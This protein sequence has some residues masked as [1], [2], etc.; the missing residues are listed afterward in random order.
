MT[1][2]GTLTS[3]RTD[4]VR[5]RSRNLL[6]EGQGALPDRGTVAITVE[7]RCGRKLLLI[8]YT[9]FWMCSVQLVPYE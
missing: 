3:G 7:L 9:D 8:A 6:Q 4:V 5:K 1:P 2:Q